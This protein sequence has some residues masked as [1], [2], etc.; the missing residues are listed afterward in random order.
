[1]PLALCL[2]ATPSLTLIG[3]DAALRLTLP[4]LEWRLARENRDR[5]C[6]AGD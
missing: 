6:D 1:M 5:F 4:E 3:S 2:G